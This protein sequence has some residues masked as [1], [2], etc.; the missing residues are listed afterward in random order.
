[1]HWI[2]KNWFLIGLFVALALGFLLAPWSETINQGGSTSTV[3]VFALFLIAGLTLPTERITQDLSRVRLHVYTQLFIFLLVPI[4]FQTARL[5]FAEQ[6]EGA[7]LVGLFALSVLPTTISTGVVLT[8]SSGGNSVAALFNAALSN[9]AGVLISPLL[10]SILLSTS[11]RALP[12]SELLE[13]LRDLS[14]TMLLPI[15]IGQLARIRLKTWIT[16]RKKTFGIVSNS[17]I[18]VIVVL[19][20]SRTAADPRFAELAPQLGWPALY[21]GIS[22]LILVA[23]AIMGAKL[24]RLPDK[25]Q[26]A[27][28]FMA[29]QKTL[30]LGAPLLTIYFSGQSV[31]GFAL[32]PLL[33]YHPLQIL[34]AGFLKSL[35]LVRRA[36]ESGKS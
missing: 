27:V 31:A 19:V 30:A 21:I 3:V 35:P 4:Y 36:Q 29:P 2:Q 28:M 13:T 20:F 25:D 17:L 11:G 5:F 26:V 24:L 12:V 16:T 23:L 22:H 7:L 8:Q 10:L 34:V 15:L 33:I 18:L 6:F 9:T 14:L 1:M 32:L